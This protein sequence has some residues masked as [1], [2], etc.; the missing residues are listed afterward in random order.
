[1]D[2]K[3][4]DE[5]NRKVEEAVTPMAD[6]IA[7]AAVKKIEPI[8]RIITILGFTFAA[9]LLWARLAQGSFDDGTVWLLFWRVEAS[10]AVYILA[11][12]MALVALWHLVSTIR[13]FVKRSRETQNKGE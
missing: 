2:K 12:G 9:V 3:S 6:E 11:T 8:T 10:P 5:L 4:Q 7:Q 1:M 13:F